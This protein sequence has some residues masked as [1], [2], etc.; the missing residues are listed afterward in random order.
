MSQSV[1]S[2]LATLGHVF[3]EANR[4]LLTLQLAKQ[5]VVR[6][7]VEDADAFTKDLIAITRRIVVMAEPSERLLRLVA[8]VA[9]EA[10]AHA[11]TQQTTQQQEQEREEEG[12]DPL[13]ALV[14]FLAQHADC[15]E[16]A[17]RFNCC[18]IMQMALQKLEDPKKL[19][20]A[21]LDRTITALRERTHDKEPKIRTIALQILGLFQSRIAEG[22]EVSLFILSIIQTELVKDVRRIAI[23]TLV[24]NSETIS[25][26]VLRTRD[27]CHESRA[28]V[29]R[30]LATFPL[31]SLNAKQIKRLIDDGLGDR[32][33]SVSKA[34]LSMI[35]SW[36]D[37]QSNTIFDVL[38]RL[39]V[40][41][42]I[43]TA[44]LL[45]SKLFSQAHP[46]HHNKQHATTTAATIVDFALW[47]F[48]TK[49]LSLAEALCWKCHLRHMKTR[50]LFGFE[51]KAPTLS[52]I[53]QIVALH[54][55]K[56]P[57]IY[58]LLEIAQMVDLS[59]ESGR[60]SLS[61]RLTDMIKTSSRS[62]APQIVETLRHLHQNENDFIKTMMEVLSNTIEPLDKYDRLE[63]I[64]D[65]TDSAV[66]E[67]ALGIMETILRAASRTETHPGLSRL[68]QFITPAIQSVRSSLRRLG[69]QC[70]A[71]FSLI[72]TQE[73]LNYLLLFVQAVK[74]D[75]NII[76][77]AA[78]RA[79]VDLIAHKGLERVAK[80]EE[81]WP[82]EY[83]RH[84]KF[85]QLETALDVSDFPSFTLSTIVHCLSSSPTS[86]SSSSSSTAAVLFSPELR[87][88]AA[89]G[90]AKL[91]L[92]NI[93]DDPQIFSIL[94]ALSFLCD[95]EQDSAL[96][97]ILET[98]FDEYS[99]SHLHHKSIWAKALIPAVK[100]FLGPRKL[101]TSHQ[102]ECK[103]MVDFCLDQTK[104]ATKDHPHIPKTLFSHNDIAIDIIN[105]MI[106]IPALE[107]FLM[108]I[109]LSLNL[110]FL[111]DDIPLMKS[112]CSK[113][114]KVFFFSSF[115][116]LVID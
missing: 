83:K 48:T 68:L 36:L 60:K 86:S 92:A 91:F 69:L 99:S 110:N 1:P 63:S 64:S 59:D 44:E 70:L 52:G 95:P 3:N 31:Q 115:F 108:K 51:E 89:E 6:L 4:G 72:D 11:Q 54:A 100:R 7:F 56:N 42:N 39:T 28:Q 17:V 88:L 104:R 5:R 61:K 21:T 30:T 35:N 79:I 43:P 97:Q 114:L 101:S 8:T 111:G 67:K 12:E 18:Q 66:Y 15:K 24:P 105:E 98:F 46:K 81:K 25:K 2:E 29:Y 57:V 14:D 113:L 10:H 106:D 37:D 45:L 75:E 112:R 32:E 27:V 50:D 87:C 103:K 116:S 73:S 58:Q 96:K 102:T 49:I 33:P 19:G 22:D 94:V 80:L 74:N 62:P 16:R 53:D 23:T 76:Q 40:A 78:V 93:L 34:C 13:I 47:D 26:F 109:L 90:L 41:K 65:P 71:L 82:S 55:G 84:P 107:P 77:I 38:D 85:S 9:L 20:T